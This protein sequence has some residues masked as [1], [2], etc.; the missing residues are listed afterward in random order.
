MKVSNETKI[1]ALTAIAITTL[2][3]GF[4]FLK[5]KTIFSKPKYIYAVFEN[6]NGLPA[7][8]APVMMKGLQIGVTG[9]A[10]EQDENVTRIIVPIKLNKNVKIPVNS[11]AVI[12]G[13]PLGLSASVIDIKGGDSTRL[14][15]MVAARK[16]QGKGMYLVPGDTIAT[17]ASLDI[18]NEVTKQLNPVLFQVQNAVHSLDSVMRA[19]GRTFDPATKSNF[20]SILAN[21]NRTTANL[22]TSTASLNQLLNTQTGALAQSLNHVN[23]FTGNLEKN[24]DKITSVLDNLEKTTKK[25][26]ELKLDETLD[27]MNK[28]VGELQG[29]IKSFNNDKG[30]LGKLLNDPAMYQNINN[31]MFSINTLV[32]DLKVNPKR[33]ISIFGRKDR[34]IKPLTRPLE[35]DSIPQ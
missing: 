25:L 29:L 21:V 31:L 27:G 13:N 4:S 11:I 15:S 24:N 32:D 10:I 18:L 34:S 6:V 23:A 28:S 30:T 2:I 35:Q 20:Q 7:S 9:E 14:A 22:I 17:N 8:T 12:T 19:I 1:G 16:A 26:S 33:Y 5:G 3:L